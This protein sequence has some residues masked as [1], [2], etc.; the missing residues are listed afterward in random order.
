M[1]NFGWTPLNVRWLE[2]IDG[3]KVLEFLEKYE[4]QTQKLMTNCL[5]LVGI[6]WKIYLRLW[7]QSDNTIKEIRNNNGARMMTSLLQSGVFRACTTCHL[8]VG[9]THEDINSYWFYIVFVCNVST[10]R[11]LIA[12]NWWTSWTCLST[13]RAGILDWTH[14]ICIS[15]I[16]LVKLNVLTIF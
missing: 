16:N 12:K 14:G 5:S 4:A 10:L 9:H 1:H 13:K 6:G 15:D 3:L 2:T 8:Q 7:L 11:S